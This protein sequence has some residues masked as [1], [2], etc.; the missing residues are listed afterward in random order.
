MLQSVFLLNSLRNFYHIS[1]N[2][3]ENPRNQ[4]ATHRR[5]DSDSESMAVTESDSCAQ[6]AWW[7]YSISPQW[8]T[9]HLAQPTVAWQ[10]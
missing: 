10:K 1:R 9:S 2:P 7:P 4:D 8:V 3:T 6:Q 5:S